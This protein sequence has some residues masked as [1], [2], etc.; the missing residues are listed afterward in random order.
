MTLSK[1][2]KPSLLQLF[3]QAASRSGEGRKKRRKG[4]FRDRER[5]VSVIDSYTLRMMLLK[6]RERARMS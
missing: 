3:L 5:G 2:Q 4:L 1:A 6:D